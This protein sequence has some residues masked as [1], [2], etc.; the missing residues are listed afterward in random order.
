MRP[1]IQHLVAVTSCCG[2]ILFAGCATRLS[3]L[4][5]RVSAE[6]SNYDPGLL[7]HRFSGYEE[8]LRFLAVREGLPQDRHSLFEIAADSEL[9]R[10]YPS[11]IGELVVVRLDYRGESRFGIRGAQGQ[12]RYYAFRVMDGAWQL[13]GIFH[14]S[15]LRWEFVGDA[16]RVFAHWHTSAFDD[17][18][19]DSAFIW[20]GR[21]FE[22]EKRPNHA[23][24]RTRHGVVV[25][26]RGVPCAGSLSLGR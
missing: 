16:I 7:K 1:F 20:N 17:P 14:A 6:D 19:D 4:D 22:Y 21:F 3:P 11:Q 18:A 9:E 12:G 24:Q 23:L 25:C 10:S 13:V 2:V 15:S 8:V 26:N 5:A